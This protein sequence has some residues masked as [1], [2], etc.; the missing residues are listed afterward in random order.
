MS[1]NRYRTQARAKQTNG[2]AMNP[3]SERGG[4]GGGGE[5]SGVS[6]GREKGVQVRERE[7]YNSCD[8]EVLVHRTARNP[9]ANPSRS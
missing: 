4:G 1:A 5:G 8:R 9:G 7:I 6:K 3:E 2:D